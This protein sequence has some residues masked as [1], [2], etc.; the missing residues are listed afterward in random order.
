MVRRAPAA[1]PSSCRNLVCCHAGGRNV[2]EP[3]RISGE[4][5]RWGARV[6][7]KTRND[8]ILE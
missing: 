7:Y 1:H 5:G 4:K 3:F 8:G 6:K 2:S